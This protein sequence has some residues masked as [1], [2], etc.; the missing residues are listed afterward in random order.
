MAT[1]QPKKQKEIKK[2][3][4][5]LLKG[6]SLNRSLKSLKLTPSQNAQLSFAEVHGDLVGTLTRLSK[7]LSDQERQQQH[8]KKVISYPVL[9]LF[10][11]FGMVLG[12]KWYI[13]PQLSDLY[14][15]NDDKNI[16]LF[17]INQSPIIILILLLM[18]SSGYLV[19]KRYLG[20][21]TEIEKANWLCKIPILKS[22]LVH[23]YTSL[24]AIEW[25]K[26]LTQ[27]MEFREVVLVMNK[28]GYTP[29]MREMAV[30]IEKQIEKGNPINLTIREWYFLKP[31]L[32]LIILQGEVK[33]D[34]GKEFLIYGNRE[35]EALIELSEKRMAFLQPIMFLLIAILIVSI[36]GA[37][38]LP[39]YSGMGDFS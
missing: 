29:L 5:S 33:G 23:Y 39:I 24:F 26:L 2:M 14:E 22:F 35:W 21:K 36:Y 30:S 32:N 25:G 3:K 37:L 16:G 38:L 28:K 34:L 9:L 18:I 20:K 12:M 17:L 6:R 27:G 8:L 15:G 4:D 19:I 7:H 1:V 13:L 11:L 31:E 10:F